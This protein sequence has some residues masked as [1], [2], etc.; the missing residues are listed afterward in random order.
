MP[1]QYFGSGVGGHLRGCAGVVVGVGFGRIQDLHQLTK[2]GGTFIYPVCLLTCR[3][4]GESS[5][6]ANPRL[7]SSSITEIRAKMTYLASGSA[8]FLPI[9]CEN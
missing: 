6:K 4:L 9:S 1:Q 5:V 8:N 7:C 3:F 2:K